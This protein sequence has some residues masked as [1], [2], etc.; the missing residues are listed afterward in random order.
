MS[1]KPNRTRQLRGAAVL[2]V[3]TISLALTLRPRSESITSQPA[4]QVRAERPDGPKQ[5]PAPT[6]VS[7]TSAST[8]SSQGLATFTCFL[9][10]RVPDQLRATIYAGD[11]SFAGVV[12]DGILTFQAPADVSRDDGRLAPVHGVSSAT[13]SWPVAVAGES[14]ACTVL[15][16]NDLVEMTVYLRGP[17]GPTTGW[18]SGCGISRTVVHSVVRLV[19]SQRLCEVQ[20]WGMGV[21]GALFG[22][23]VVSVESDV[24]VVISLAAADRFPKDLVVE[25]AREV[26]KK[27]EE[28]DF[29]ELTLAM[30][31]EDGSPEVIHFQRDLEDTRAMHEGMEELLR[32]IEEHLA[33]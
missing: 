10:E 32:Q 1:T 30:A 22:M 5:I 2:V 21:D 14:V 17:Q 33:E 23:A 15:E 29:V 12:V 6:V 13:L 31:E 9:G 16:V 7:K 4:P 11:D 27:A 25:I 18:L 28:V 20:A 26:H 8:P 24:D 19:P 3:L